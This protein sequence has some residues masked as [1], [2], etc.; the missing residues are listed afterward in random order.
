MV[1]ECNSVSD[2]SESE[3]SIHDFGDTRTDLSKIFV[4]NIIPGARQSRSLFVAHDRLGGN[5]FLVEPCCIP[6]IIL[7][8]VKHDEHAARL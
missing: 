2:P 7:L 5:S 4:E 1:Q 8:K 6:H 3:L